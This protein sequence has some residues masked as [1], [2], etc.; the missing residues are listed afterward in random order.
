MENDLQAALPKSE[1]DMVVNALQALW[2]ERVNA[3]NVAERVAIEHRAAPAE[4]S[5]FG[6]DEVAQMLRRF[7]AAPSSL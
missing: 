7:G 1:R 6:I 3:F 2:R 5:A 4:R